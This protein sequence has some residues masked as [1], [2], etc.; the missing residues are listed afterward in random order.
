VSQNKTQTQ[1]FCDNF[2]NCAPILII[3]SLLHSTMYCRRT[4][5]IIRHLTSTLLLHYRVKF[6]CSTAQLYTIVIHSKVWNR[7]FP[8]NIYRNVIFWIICLCQ[9]IYNIK[10]A[11][12]ISTHALRCAR[13]F[14]NGCINDRWLQCCAKRIAWRCRNLLCWHNVKWRRRHLEKTTK[15]K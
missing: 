7:L 14:V 8:V 1:S 10:H 4:Y 3:L 9:L 6:E 15:L 13:H 11:F 5:Y 12:K 2:G